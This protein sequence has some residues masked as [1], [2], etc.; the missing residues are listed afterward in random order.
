MDIEI[1]DEGLGELV[2]W[3]DPDENRQ[4]IRENKPRDLRDKRTS[5][6]E[7]VAKFVTNGSFIAFGGFGHIRIPMSLVYEIIRQEK[8]DLVVAGKTA[9]H[10]IDLLIGAGCVA[11]IEVAYAFGHE[12][13]GLS[14]AGRRA[15]ESGQCQVIAEISNAGYQ[16]RFL[17]GMLGIPFIPSR[18]MLGSD[19]FRRSSCKMARDPWTGKTVCLI[20]AAYPDVAMFHVPRCDRFGNAQ[21]DGIIVEDF[22]LA[23]AARRV[24]I[25]TEEVVEPEVIQQEPCRT[26]IPYYVVDAVIEVPFGAH[27]TNMPYLYFFDEEHIAEWLECS[28]TPEGPRVYF[29]KYVFG[30]RDF[31]DYLERVGGVRKLNYLKR[32]EQFKA[33]MVVPWLKGK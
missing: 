8:R 10:D 14:P 31:E 27:P 7:A 20:P 18:N 29:Q 24:I 2:G 32:V 28:K 33:P 21:I 19:T 30:V 16:W 11:K 26:V 13:R 22:E 25:T 4:W 1:L 15:V 9:V 5:V 17:A 12:L 23:R 3:H 6:A